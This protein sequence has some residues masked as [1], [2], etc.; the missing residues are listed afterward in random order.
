MT[1]PTL[2][3]EALGE[4][5]LLLAQDKLTTFMKGLE[6]VRWI[7]THG[8]NAVE[9][10]DAQAKALEEARAALK[11]F[12]GIALHRDHDLCGP[13][14]ID[15]PDLNITP[16]EVRRARSFLAVHPEERESQPEAKRSTPRSN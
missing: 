15:G 14:M 1:K 6:A 10:I 12:A 3:K 2:G 11:P 5:L 13:D 16:A 9:T 4:L 7:R 8:P